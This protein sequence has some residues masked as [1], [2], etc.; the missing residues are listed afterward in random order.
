MSE[1]QRVGVLLREEESADG[2][3]GGTVCLIQ[4]K[5]GYRFSLDAVLLA[6]FAAEGRSR[7]A[8]D[9]GCGCGVVGLC[10]LAL[11]GAESLAGVDLQPDMVDRAK[12]ASEWNGFAERARFLEGDLRSIEGLLPPRSADLAVS[13][14]PYRRMGEGKVSP[15]AESA[16]ARHEV[17]CTLD[18]VVAAAAYLLRTRGVFCLVYPASRAAGAVESC[19][20]KGL[21]PRELWPVYPVAGSAASL[22]LLRAVKGAP[23]G[24]TVRGPLFLHGTDEKYSVEAQALLGP[25]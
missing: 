21:E 9:L 2:A 17:A 1:R 10:L 24:L 14:P 5:K 8:V 13:N 16:L 22:V 15:R 19:R 18:D 7:R 25:P 6:R 11:R 4:P 3:L 23:E 20:R 12:R